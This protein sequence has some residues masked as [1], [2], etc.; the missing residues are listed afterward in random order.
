[1]DLF[2]GHIDPGYGK[3]SEPNNIRNLD[4][5]LGQTVVIDQSLVGGL[6]HFLFFHILE[7]II[8]ID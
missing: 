8:P 1:M 7:I 6:E 3:A 5:D 4:L 2:A